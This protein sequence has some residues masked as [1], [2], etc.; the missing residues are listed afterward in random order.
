ME[1]VFEGDGVGA[2]V[3]VGLAV[4]MLSIALT[5]Y[6]RRRSKLFPEGCLPP[7]PPAWP[8]IGH[9]H[10]LSNKEQPLHRTLWSLAQRYGPIM[11][12]RLGSRPLLV[13]SSPEAARECLTT[14]DVVFASRPSSSISQ[15]LGYNSTM[16]GLDPYTQLW[17]S[18]RRVCNTEILSVAR[19]E[20][21]R[22]GRAE[23]IS[24]LVRSLFESTQQGVQNV[25][26]RQRLL[27]L[28]FDSILRMTI[29]KRY[30]SNSSNTQEAQQFQRLMDDFLHLTRVLN[31]GDYI[32]WLRWLDLQGYERQM[33]NSHRRLDAFLQRL[34]EEHRDI[35]KKADSTNS[36]FIDVLLSIFAQDD[37]VIKATALSMILAGTHTSAIAIEWAMASLIQH[38]EFCRKAQNELDTHVGRNRIVEEVGGYHIPPGTR[39]LVNVWAIHRD[40]T[41]W[42]KPLEFQPE[43]FVS[44]PTGQD[45]EFIPFGSGRRACAGSS[46]GLSIVQLSLARLLQS[47]DWSAPNGNTALDM[48]ENF[49]VAF[50]RAA[51][52]EAVIKPRL[53]NHLY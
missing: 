37:S 21:S 44:K 24:A 2:I 38:P 7:G 46:L 6:R 36:D 13:V 26:L 1:Y 3:V 48:T 15:H 43:R 53:P 49:R 10:L 45:F 40:P 30:Y 34:V 32:P 18:V 16:L 11:H 14:N 25:K 22:H 23:E 35:R 20:L 39:L 29:G 47:F 17:R 42:E 9:F 33:K 4:V 51:P 5:I 28:T 27:D 31:I 52:L 19:I 41:V 50:F 12:L 8:I